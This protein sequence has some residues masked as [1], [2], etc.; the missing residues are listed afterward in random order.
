MEKMLY[1]VPE[2]AELL[3]VGTSTLWELIRRD[4]IASVSIGHLRRI[5]KDALQAFIDDLAG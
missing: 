3:G 5:P 1:T 2:A 4:R